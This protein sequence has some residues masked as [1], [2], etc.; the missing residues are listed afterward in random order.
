[1]SDVT[2]VIPTFDRGPLL[3]RSVHSVLAQTRR[4]ARVIV[5]DNGEQPTT[6]R[7]D[8]PIV[9]VVRTA[10]RIGPSRPRNIGA[11]RATT[12]LVAFLDDDDLWLPEF[13]EHT[14]AAFAAEPNAAAVVGRVERRRA[15]GTQTPYKEFPSD[16]EAQRAIYFKNPG[17]AGSYITLKRDL[18]LAMGGFDTRMPASVDRDLA[19]RLLERGERIAVAPNAVAV[20]C[21]HDGARV[22]GNQVRGNRMFL[23]KHWSAMRWDERW[24]AS[25]TLLKRWYRYSLTQRK[26]H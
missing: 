1:M 4:P 13:L 14:L 7:F 23:I 25:R 19:A 3:E 2:V 10:P 9:D 22:R 16:P 18:L 8:D 12:P 21:D 24:K 6:A 17:F 20:L 26:V 11:E 15:D 5:V